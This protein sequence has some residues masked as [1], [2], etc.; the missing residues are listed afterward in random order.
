MNIGIDSA[1]F[2]KMY[3]NHLNEIIL[4]C[5]RITPESLKTTDTILSKIINGLSYYSTRA[6]EIIMTYLPYRRFNN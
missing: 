2:S 6:I 5:Q 3:Q 1:I 4:Q